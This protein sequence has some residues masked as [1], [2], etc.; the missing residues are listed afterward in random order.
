MRSFKMQGLRTLPTFKAPSSMIRWLN[1]CGSTALMAVFL[2]LCHAVQ[3]EDLNNPDYLTTD[4]VVLIT[5][6][7]GFIGSELAL[8]LHRTYG[9]KKLIL[10]DSMDRGFGGMTPESVLNGKAP[11][12]TEADLALLEF[13][14]QRVFRVMQELGPTAHFYRVDFRPNVPEFHEAGEVPVLHHIFTIHSDITHVVHLA[15]HYHRGSTFEKRKQDQLLTQT[16]P[17]IHGQPK[18]GMMESLLEELRVV[19]KIQTLPHF[20][21]AST[22]EVYNFRGDKSN[23]P[24]FQEDKPLSTP[25]SFAGASKLMD[26]ILAQTYYKTDDIYSVGLRFFSV[27]GPWGLPGSPLYEMAER[28]IHGNNPLELDTDILHDIRDFVYIDD[29]IDAIMSAMQFRH[30]KPVVFNVG[31]GTGSTLLQVGK[32]ME[33][34]VDGKSLAQV[35]TEDP[36]TTSIAHNGR[37][38]RVLGFKPHVSLEQGLERLLAWHYDRAYP[39][40]PPDDADDR[41]QISGKGI[42]ACNKYDKECLLGAAVFPCASE[43][44]HE[45]QCITSFYDDVQ[46]YTRVLTDECDAVM[47]TVAL[48]DSLSVIPSA[49]VQVSAN[50]K[51]HIEGNGGRCN[52]AFVSESS[53]LFRR[54]SSSQAGQGKDVPI[55]HGHWVLVPVMVSSHVA[56]MMHIL[57]LLPKLSPSQFFG[58][59]T[60]RAIYCDPTVVLDNVSLLLT[61]FDK[62]PTGADGPVATGLLIGKQRSGGQGRLLESSSSVRERIQNTAYRMI[63]IAAIDEMAGD[64]FS[65]HFD[66]SFMIHALTGD[67]TRLFR[68]DIFGEVIQWDVT[69]D[70]S[71]IEFISGLHDMWSRVIDKKRDSQPWWTG[72]NMSERKDRHSDLKSNAEISVKQVPQVGKS[73]RRLQEVGEEDFLGQGNDVVGVGGMSEAI[74]DAVRA[75]FGESINKQLDQDDDDD[76]SPDGDGGNHA[77]EHES[78][79]VVLPLSG[80]GGSDSDTWIGILS[81]ADL[82]YYAHIVDAKNFGVVHLDEY[83]GDS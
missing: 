60:T 28:A 65:M 1:R 63:R 44:A 35:A 54:L 16:I 75:V 6:A 29:A 39:Y 61:E 15:D 23:P 56:E 3:S 25:S 45:T 10:I 21:Y 59:R 68:C 34:A 50:S 42:V 17:R 82:R 41:K 43:C 49:Q 20:V 80:K 5:G 76:S 30:E 67:D 53:P 36:E 37:A 57:K 13:K 47:Y 14:R 7:G 4:S 74:Q 52:I 70:A 55:M 66:S 83:A 40:G 69:A 2:L 51:S 22:H 81:S 62:K 8:A 58:S 18:A 11:E 71:S 31:S 79:D 78:A 38:E 24:P 9:P 48:D 27:Y 46:A 72:N 32:L 64:G 26:E 77:I 33:V 19:K 12:K 73:R